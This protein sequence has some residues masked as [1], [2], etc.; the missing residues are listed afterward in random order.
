M[1][2]FPSNNSNHSTPSQEADK[3][4]DLGKYKSDRETAELLK[5]ALRLMQKVNEQLLEVQRILEEENEST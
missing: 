5:K 3:V 4:V 2:E 1:S